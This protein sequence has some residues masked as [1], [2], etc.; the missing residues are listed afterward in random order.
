MS[1]EIE[2]AWPKY[3]DYRIDVE[4]S[5]FRGRVW[6]GGVLVAESDRCLLVRETDHVD[7]LY[8]PHADVRWEHFEPSVAHTI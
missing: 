1:P 5:A 6:A 4:P 2:S 7:R 3:P 8:F